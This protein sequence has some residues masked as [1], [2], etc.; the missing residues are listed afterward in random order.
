[1]RGPTII[2]VPNISIWLPH[3][4]KA[5]GEPSG[6]GVNAAFAP[7]E[8]QMPRASASPL[9]GAYV[10]MMRPRFGRPTN[11]Q[12]GKGLFLR[13]TA[14]HPNTGRRWSTYS[15]HVEMR[16]VRFD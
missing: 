4:A 5:P 7:D 14:D 10:S 11:R 6:A 12:V 8:L 16:V 2:L 13:S 1:V 3:F 9:I 15:S